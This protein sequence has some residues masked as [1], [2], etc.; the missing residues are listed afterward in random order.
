VSENIINFADHVKNKRGPTGD[1]ADEIF[2]AAVEIGLDI[3]EI[4]TSCLILINVLC[5][6][7]PE[8]IE[9]VRQ[10]AQEIIGKP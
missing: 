8:H 2:D 7:R 10:V 5:A 6:V 3:P 9:G 1:F 4:I